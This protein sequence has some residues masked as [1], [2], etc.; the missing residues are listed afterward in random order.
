VDS[1][2]RAAQSERC[3]RSPTATHRAAER[4]LEQTPRRYDY[5]EVARHNDEQHG[6]WLVIDGAV[7]DLSEFVHHHPGGRRIVQAYAGMD[8]THGFARAHAGRANVDSLRERYRIGVVRTPSSGNFAAVYR[9]F[10]SA[11]QLLVEMQNALAADQSLQTERLARRDDAEERTPYKLLRA[12]ETHHRFV[13]SYLNVLASETLPALWHISQGPL[14]PEA[15]PG[16]LKKELEHALGSEEA[17]RCHGL[18]D[19]IMRDF[20]AWKGDPRTLDLA[21]AIERLDRDLLSGIKAAL[22]LALRELERHGVHVRQLGGP[23]VRTGCEQAAA[24][25]RAYQRQ[26]SQE[27]SCALGAP[28]KGRLAR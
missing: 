25:V 13:A 7:Y 10:V 4:P 16:W 5:S 26:L 9:A 18:I 6:Y 15:A 2:L 12:F 3:Q 14:F 28:S 11:L 23:H 19:R 1:E 24:L 21:L 22:I 27:L 17:C 8:A 20:D